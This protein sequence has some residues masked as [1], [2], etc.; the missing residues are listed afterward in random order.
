MASRGANYNGHFGMAAGLARLPVAGC[1][2]L[3]YS[4]ADHDGHER[5]RLTVWGS[6]DGGATWPLTRLV[7][8]GPSAYSSRAAGR[9]GV[10]IM[11]ASTA[12]L[13][14]TH[15]MSTLH[16]AGEYAKLDGAFGG[17][18]GDAYYTLGGVKHAWTM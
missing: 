5:V 13:F 12:R 14:S 9:P 10:R 16:A 17:W 18:V 8:G 7:D 4:N 6:L 3:L 2:I 1:D 11:R 15:L